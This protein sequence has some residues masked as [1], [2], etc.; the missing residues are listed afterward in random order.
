MKN[1]LTNER[2]QISNIQNI[3]AFN[4]SRNKKIYMNTCTHK[5]NAMNNC[6]P[7]I[8]KIKWMIVCKIHKL[9]KLTQEEIEKLK[10]LKSYKGDT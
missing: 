6:V 1:L 8:L 7:I 9:L 2:K 4:F 5:E 10:S 3:H